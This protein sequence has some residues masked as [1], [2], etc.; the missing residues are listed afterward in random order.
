MSWQTVG[1]VTISPTTDSAVVG[2]VEVPTTGGLRVKL[3]Q[4]GSVP[5]RWGFGL[6][7]YESQNGLELGTIQVFPRPVFTSYLLGPGMIVDDPQGQLIFEPRT[8]NL[9][10]IQAGF[11]LAIEVLAYISAGLPVDRYTADGFSTST[12]QLIPLILSGSLGRLNFQP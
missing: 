8:W 3:R 1:T 11:D 4:V 5:F 7:S 10:W 2:P 9:R 12:G 6:L